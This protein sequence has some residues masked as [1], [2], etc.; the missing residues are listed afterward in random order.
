M[1]RIS[2]ILANQASPL[3]TVS[4]EYSSGAPVRGIRYGQGLALWQGRT[5]NGRCKG[6]GLRIPPLEMPKY[7]FDHIDIVD[8]CDDRSNSTNHAPATRKSKVRSFTGFF[9]PGI[10]ALYVGFTPVISMDRRNTFIKFLCRR[11]KAQGFPWSIIQLTSNI[12]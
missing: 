3:R 6:V 7:P 5:G 11:A 8:E 2:R 1:W 4:P 10:S 12:V 9:V